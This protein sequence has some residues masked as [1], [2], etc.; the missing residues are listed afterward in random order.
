MKS[1]CYV[2]RRA[3]F[4]L[5][6]FS[7]A[8]GDCF[9][10]S[11]TN[12]FPTT[13]NV[14]IGTTSPGNRLTLFDNL[15]TGLY[16][17]AFIGVS[18]ASRDI[19]LAGQQG[20]SN[21]FTVQYDGSKM[22]YA[23]RDGDALMST[24]LFVGSQTWHKAGDTLLHVREYAAGNSVGAR[25]ENLNNQ[26]GDIGLIVNSSYAGAAGHSLKVQAQG[27]DR[28]VVRGDGFVGVG[29]EGGPLAKL[30]V[31]GADASSNGLSAA[32]RLTNSSP[33][34]AS[35][36]LRAGAS[37]TA[38]PAGGFSIADDVA[39]RVLIQN[40]GFVSIGS[41]APVARLHVS[42]AESDINGLGAAVRISN[43][44]TGGGN[45]ILRAGASGTATPAGGF[46][47]AD[48]LSYKLSIDA[49]GNVGI[50]T[51]QPTHKLS[52]NGSIR[53]KEVVVETTG[54]AD[55]VLK[56]GYDLTP[57]ADV[58]KHIEE[59][60]HLPGIPSA[61]QVAERGVNVGDMQAKLLAKIEELT[62]HQIR[63]EKEIVRLREKLARAGLE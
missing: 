1:I 18:G 52:V 46:S 63:Q 9:A 24:D 59:H 27:T 19:L 32:V 28:L 41:V 21:G 29:S 61:D 53:A 31:G 2:A 48:D 11:S 38:T 42:G 39:Y 49:A 43:S 12:T 15:P 20:V 30:H 22:I 45:W 57:L 5:A 36:N 8:P 40:N 54:W 56:P 50:G 37:G 17:A 4:F 23:M 34:G 58:E 10:Q 25:I 62:L 47:I 13:G 33:G 14:G 35:W 55:Y 6:A 51:L 44:S 16:G 7:L 26:A 3:A 60:G